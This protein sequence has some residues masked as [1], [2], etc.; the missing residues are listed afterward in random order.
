MSTEPRPV[1]LARL[2]RHSQTAHRQPDPVVENNTPPAVPEPH[3]NPTTNAEPHE[4][5]VNPSPL[6]RL[7]AAGIY[8]PPSHM[9][10]NPSTTLPQLYVRPAPAVAGLLSHAFNPNA[11]LGQL[12]QPSA[13]AFVGSNTTGRQ[14]ASILR[15][16]LGDR[17]APVCHIIIYPFVSPHHCI[18]ATKNNDPHVQRAYAL[19]ELDIYNLK[20]TDVES[21][22][23]HMQKLDLCITY[24]TTSNDTYK[25]IHAQLLAHNADSTKPHIP[26]LKTENLD[27]LTFD[28]MGWCFLHLAT[29]GLNHALLTFNKN[30]KETQSNVSYMIQYGSLESKF[31]V[32][33]KRKN[34]AMPGQFTIVIAPTTAPICHNLLNRNLA[35]HAQ[36]ELRYATPGWQR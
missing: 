15:M 23:A 18:Q 26:G 13:T 21:F 7:T 34:L 12:P 19:P 20:E 25:D 8:P 5:N 35:G 1:T 16:T 14:K 22:R 11:F 3:P 2:L 29:H 33:C 36:S 10:A 4:S 28:N 31:N 17:Q 32:H 9:T 24:R 30:H 27:H 6:F